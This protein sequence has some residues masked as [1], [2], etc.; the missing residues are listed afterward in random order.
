MRV[1]LNEDWLHYIWTRQEVDVTEK[2]L[3]DF[4]IQYKNTTITDFLFNVNG[5]VSTSPSDILETWTDKYLAKEENGVKVDYTNTW[6]KRAYDIYNV[7]G[8]DMYAVF[9]KT[10]K[11]V[12]IN[13]WLSIRMND[14]HC[15]MKPTDIR[16]SS[17]VE[18]NSDKWISAHRK[19]VGYFDRCFDY[20]FPEVRKTML[21]YIKEQLTRYDVYGIELDFTREPFCF[22]CGKEDDGIPVMTAFVADVK[23]TVDEIGA[24]R[25][26]HI[27][28]SILG[29]ANPV[30]A[31]KTGFDFPAMARKGLIDLY[32]ASPRWHTINT[33]IPI[34]LWK[35]LLGD[36]VGF[37]CSQGLLFSNSY[38]LMK[39]VDVAMDMGQTAANVC[40]GCDIVYLYN[41]FDNIEDGLDDLFHKDAFR[42]E[43]NIRYIYENIGKVEEYE[44]W[45]RRI[46]VTHDDFCALNEKIALRL[47]VTTKFEQF[48]LPT[49]KIDK[50]TKVFVHLVLKEKIDGASIS[51]YANGR[52]AEFCENAKDE[53]IWVDGNV[54]TFC[55]TVKTKKIVGIETLF[56]E[57]VNVCYLDVVIPPAR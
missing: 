38:E 23:K 52:K 2:D 36:K 22:A 34:E 25:G 17:L 43:K 56:D 14:A 51:L 48:R 49:G 29:Q 27:Y 15:N 21:S 42:T 24:A 46:P 39:M 26:K 55:V 3:K 4:I 28:L 37:G 40:R 19:A 33:D 11:E 12:G 53:I 5:T 10:C 32:V 1:F 7:K 41:H 18:K 47:P 6:A 35:D 57:V 9:I 50:E 54:Y 16:K 13:P 44:K 45:E 20:S 31:L 30:S 8:I